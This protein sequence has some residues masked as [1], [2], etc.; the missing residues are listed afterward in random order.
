MKRRKLS[1]FLR[2]FAFLTITP[3]VTFLLCGCVFHEGYF[4]TG[5]DLY[6]PAKNPFQDPLYVS[7][8]GNTAEPESFTFLLFTDTHFIRPDSGVYYATE[9]FENWLSSDETRALSIEFALCLGDAT[10]DSFESE[11][12]TYVRFVEKL[13]TVY[14]LT[15][16][17]VMGNHDNR[18]SGTDRWKKHINTPPYYRFVHKG[19][20]FYMLDTSYRT[21][22]KKQM[23][24][25]SETIAEDGNQKLFCTHFPLY[26]KPDLFYFALADTQE[27]NLIIKLMTKNNVGMYL[28]GHHHKGDV[29]YQYTDTCTEFIAGAFHGRDNILE[30]PAR[31][32]VCQYDA[33]RNTLKITRHT[34]YNSTSS[35]DDIEKTCMG[36]FQL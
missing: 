12:L 20:S 10:D 13:D 24:Y 7:P 16:Y 22:G 36:I 25:L 15:C 33:S 11:Y 35:V 4:V 32:Y 2:S 5:A 31:W 29:V 17:S 21:L 18:G 27:R 19:I 1:I 23:G 3:A 6:S 8:A 28:S 30:G 9:A 14:G 34:K 26:G